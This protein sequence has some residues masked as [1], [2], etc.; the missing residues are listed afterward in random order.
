MSRRKTKNVLLMK[1]QVW[2]CIATALFLLLL[3][4][5]LMAQTS[6]NAPPDEATSTYIEEQLKIIE[7][8]QSKRALF[9]ASI[10]DANVEFFLSGSWRTGIGASLIVPLGNLPN[11]KDYLTGFTD[12]PWFNQAKLLLSVWYDQKF[13]LDLSISETEIADRFLLGYKDI[14]QQDGLYQW[15]LGNQEIGVPNYGQVPFS[16]GADSSPGTL[17]SLRN[18]NAELHLMSRI[19]GRSNIVE[20]FKGVAPQNKLVIKPE[21]FRKGQFFVGPYQKTSSMLVYVQSTQGSLASDG[22]YYQVMTPEDFLYFVPEQSKFG[23]KKN[24]SSRVILVYQTAGDASPQLFANIENSGDFNF[25]SPIEF[26]LLDES[27]FA[28]KVLRPLASYYGWNLDTISANPSDL[29]LT[30]EGNVGLLIFEPGL[31]SPF[32]DY[33]WY[34]SGGLNGQIELSSSNGII[35]PSQVRF[36]FLQV[37][38]QGSQDAL[39]ARYPLIQTDLGDLYLPTGIA[40]SH[41]YL[42]ALA[43]QGKAGNV[44]NLSQK[45]LPASINVKVNGLINY[46]WQLDDQGRNLS[47]NTVEARDTVIVSYQIDEKN[48]LSRSLQV[49]ASGKYSL[50]PLDQLKAGIAMEVPI[51]T[52]PLNQSISNGIVASGIEFEHTSLDKL[53]RLNLSTNFSV[54][55]PDSSRLVTLQSYEDDQYVFLTDEAIALPS[56]LPSLS[57]INAAISQGSYLTQNASQ[58]PGPPLSEFGQANR[59]FSVKKTIAHTSGQLAGWRSDGD[60]STQTIPAEVGPY[61]ANNE[62]DDPFYSNVLVSSFLASA[63]RNTASFELRLPFENRSLLDQTKGIEFWV[64]TPFTDADLD[65]FV[66]VGILS[67]DLDQDNQLDQLDSNLQGLI[68]RHPDWIES[69]IVKNNERDILAK[70][71]DRNGNGILEQENSNA[72]DTRYVGR[73]NASSSGVWR[74]VVISRLN[75]GSQGAAQAIR[76]FFRSADNNQDGTADDAL[77]GTVLLGGFSLLLPIPDST[78]SSSATVSSSIS[79]N[80]S[81]QNTLNSN[82]PSASSNGSKMASVVYQA[83]LGEQISI[84]QNIGNRTL[85]DGS[86]LTWFAFFDDNQAPPSVKKISIGGPDNLFFVQE[87][88]NLNAGTWYQFEADLIGLILSIYSQE[89]LLIESFN[90]ARHGFSDATIDYVTMDL[91]FNSA[92]SGTLY[93]DHFQLQKPIARSIAQFNALLNWSLPGLIFGNQEFAILQDLSIRQIARLKGGSVVAANY[94]SSDQNTLG[95]TIDG[96]YGFTLLYLKTLIGLKVDSLFDQSPALFRYALAFPAIPDSPI[97]AKDSFSFDPLSLMARYSRKNSLEFLLKPFLSSNFETLIA[98]SDGQLSREYGIALSLQPSEDLGFSAKTTINQSSLHD[99]QQSDFGNAWGYSWDL[100]VNNLEDQ[101]FLRSNRLLAGFFAKGSQEKLQLN[102]DL[103]SEHRLG[104]IVLP[105]AQLLTSLSLGNEASGYIFSTSY[106]RTLETS[107]PPRE[108]DLATDYTD[109]FY[110]LSYLQS[111]TFGVPFYELWA[112]DRNALLAQENVN[113]GTIT[114]AATSKF[115]LS[116]SLDLTALSLIFPKTISLEFARR[117]ISETAQTSDRWGLQFKSEWRALNLFGTFGSSK[118]VEFYESD[119][120]SYYISGSFEWPRIGEAI[121]NLAEGIKI[122]L[123]GLKMDGEN[124]N[125]WKQVRDDI[126]GLLDFGSVASLSISQDLVYRYDEYESLSQ[127][128]GIEFTWAADLPPWSPEIVG[129]ASVKSAYL[130]NKEQFSLQINPE[131]RSLKFERSLFPSTALASQ[132]DGILFSIKHGSHLIF[133]GLA[134]ISAELGIGYGQDY[135]G[136]NARLG[137]FARIEAQIKL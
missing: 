72:V 12:E 82:F 73:L 28:T 47:L 103:G 60:L 26:S 95:F 51:L 5:L 124:N 58:N 111:Y 114:W 45:A 116:R 91:F 24:A 10:G 105:K 88:I 66:Q 71:E 115:S 7:A 42:E 2:L 67:E 17:F 110:P 108:L 8:E 32:E 25:G 57:Q 74:K 23:L 14:K 86:L 63:D 64:R 40:P 118:S 56:A 129:K 132:N 117:I 98:L 33:S 18:E 39:L 55:I 90:L 80:V 84:R 53:F 29:F 136:L 30:I 27:L 36:S 1:L 89:G 126:A 119:D 133:P 99:G 61:L 62:G 49:A 22:N 101:V 43:A 77:S 85:D 65:L 41:S 93:L 104:S 19:V 20:Y 120:F 16:L 3:P 135:S 112:D 130:I 96:E 50:S 109:V 83:N 46:V 70:G 107:R 102:I 38:A 121:L 15:L 75:P 35:F 123:F 11:N 131:S 69:V 79:D 81:L 106:V 48:S 54:T 6:V 94:Q 113:G 31:F 92:N 34:S 87:N 9:S 76:F 78:Q 128:Y 125:S 100:L 134:R 13:F 68:L 59:A 97:T 137:F 37:I 4:E 44:L 122:Q 127:R 52:D 21:S